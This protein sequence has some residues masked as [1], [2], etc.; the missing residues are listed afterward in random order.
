MTPSKRRVSYQTVGLVCCDMFATF[1]AGSAAIL[2]NRVSRITGT[3]MQRPLSREISTGCEASSYIIDLGCRL[4]ALRSLEWRWT[5]IVA[6]ACYG[7]AMSVRYSITANGKRHQDWVI[8]SACVL[9]MM[10]GN[11]AGM[12][13]QEVLFQV[14]PGLTLA[15][16]LL[17]SFMFDAADLMG[18]RS[19]RRLVAM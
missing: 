6:I 9:G 5:G 11:L 7:I 4:G 15:S 13:P 3:D 12:E 19:Q 8:V 1:V 17:S 10:A 2:M 16:L 14:L 18:A